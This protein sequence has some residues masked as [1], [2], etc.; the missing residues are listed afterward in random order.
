[1]LVE[2]LSDNSVHEMGLD[3]ENQWLFELTDQN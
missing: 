2:R 3:A 1:M